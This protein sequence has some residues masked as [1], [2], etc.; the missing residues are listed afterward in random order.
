MVGLLALLELY[1][2][3]YLVTYW[4]LFYKLR[5]TSLWSG[6]KLF[7]YN[8]SIILNI[9]KEGLPPSVNMFMMA[10]GMYII[11]YFVAVFGKE[12][13]AGFGIGMRIEQMFLMP[14]V[15]LSVASLSIISQNNGAK[16]YDRIDPTIKLSLYYGWTIS[17]I[18]VI[19]FWLF[20]DLLA[21][22][23][24]TDALVIYQ[25]SLYLKISGF[26]SYGF[27][28]IFIY[29]S[30]FQG[31]G[32]PNIIMP[33]SIFRQILAPILMFVVFSNFHFGIDMYW[34]G[35]DIIVFT[36]AIFLYVFK[37]RTISF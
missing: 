26:A 22:F 6:I 28:V 9:I 27:V 13:V 2:F 33:I 32:K 20:S 21:S 34:I 35:I 7:K 18:G 5:Q 8:K 36:S 17:T 19:S 25:A 10:L 16:A 37:K 31:V 30:M 3:G 15:G 12:V 1:L 24:S 29:I 23:L 4:H 14:I 11:T